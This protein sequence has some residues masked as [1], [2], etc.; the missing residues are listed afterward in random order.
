M[1]DYS[2]NEKITLIAQAC[3][4]KSSKR[5]IARAQFLFSGLNLNAKHVLEIGC[6]QGAW[7]LWAGMCGASYVLGVEPESTGSTQG[8]F[9]LFQ[10]TIDEVC[11]TNHVEGKA[12]HIQDLD[13][14][15]AFDIIMAYDVINHFSEAH[16]RTLH[17]PQSHQFYVS[18]FRHIRHLLKPDGMLIVADS[19]RRNFFG[20]LRLANPLSPTID[21]DIHQSPKSWLEVAQEAG[22]KLR[23]IRWSYVYPFTGITVRAWIAYF[24]ASH[25]VL[26]MQKT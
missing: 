3:G 24:L 23:D 5:Y 4:Y 13:A 26:R 18:I 12:L 20:D 14:E 22:F 8:T 10:K 1:V 19:S 2:A 17:L 9:H 6:G 25:F 15:G 16:T 7:A 21:W 11:L